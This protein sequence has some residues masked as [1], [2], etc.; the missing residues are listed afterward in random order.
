MNDRNLSTPQAIADII[1]TQDISQS[2][3]SEAFI[4]NAKDKLYADIVACYVQSGEYNLFKKGKPTDDFAD[5]V[6]LN[7]YVRESS[8]KTL[9]SDGAYA[10]IEKIFWDTVQSL[11]LQWSYTREYL[12]EELAY[13]GYANTPYR[14]WDMEKFKNPT[15]QPQKKFVVLVNSFDSL[16]LYYLL[17]EKV[18]L[19]SRYI[20][21]TYECNV[22][23]YVGFSKLP[24][25]YAMHF[26]VFDTQMEYEHFLSMTCLD[27]ISNAIR[28]CLRVHDRW[29]VMDSCGYR[30]Q[31]RVWSTF[32][33][34][35]RMCLLREAH[36]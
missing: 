6:L 13:Y 16:A 20:R 25:H 8:L 21:Q 2:S 28:E 34:E 7:L 30:P 26:I 32:S 36:A 3:F 35:E 4:R 11:D 14:Q 31:Y 9:Q 10:K 23:V 5:E 27:E 22:K 12:P 1:K 24:P 18:V 33:G 17:S 19:V 29:N 15:R